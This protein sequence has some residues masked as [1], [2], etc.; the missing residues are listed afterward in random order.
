[1]NYE[2]SR[3][4]KAVPYR[5]TPNERDCPLRADRVSSAYESKVP[6]GSHDGW[7][8]TAESVHEVRSA[9]SHGQRYD[10][11]W[12]CDSPTHPARSDYGAE[13]QGTDSET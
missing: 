6:E 3:S 4:Y 11:V 10:H 7:K 2:T 13:G 9:H 5:W 8:G 12:R 1:M